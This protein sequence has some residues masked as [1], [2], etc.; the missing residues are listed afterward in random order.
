MVIQQ[1]RV[2]E[3]L[4]RIDPEGTVLRSWPHVIVTFLKYSRKNRSFHNS[5]EAKTVWNWRLHSSNPV[6]VA[7]NIDMLPSG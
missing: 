5:F 2:R 7:K 3:S 4:Q 6:T 1:S